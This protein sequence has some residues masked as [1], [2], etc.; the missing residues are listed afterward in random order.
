MTIK[1]DDYNVYEK[2]DYNLIKVYDLKVK[3]KYKDVIKFED[4]WE[5]FWN[6]EVV[7]VKDDY[8]IL[9]LY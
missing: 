1:N 7:K 8:A 5:M 3:L 4:T 2:I 9:Y 6:G